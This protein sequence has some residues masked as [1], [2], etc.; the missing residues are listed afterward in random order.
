MPT[1]TFLPP[2]HFTCWASVSSVV[3][4]STATVVT[5]E[6][7]QILEHE[8]RGTRHVDAFAGLVVVD[9]I[10]VLLA[11]LLVGEGRVADLVAAS[12]GCRR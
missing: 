3:P 10:H 9:E 11:R 8:L 1:V 4:A 5:T 2:A 12:L 6:T 7:L